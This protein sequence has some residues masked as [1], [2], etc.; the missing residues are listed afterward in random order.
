MARARDTLSGVKHRRKRPLQRWRVTCLGRDSNE[1]PNRPLRVSWGIP[2]QLSHASKSYTLLCGLLSLQWVPTRY[3]GAITPARIER[4]WCGV[5]WSVKPF[6]RWRGLLD[7]RT[8]IPQSTCGTFWEDGLQ[9]AVCREAPS[10]SS[11]K[12]YYRNGRYCHNK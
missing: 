7:H 11:N 9:V 10:K 6:H 1:W 2:T 3:L 4:D 12:P 8:L 5:I